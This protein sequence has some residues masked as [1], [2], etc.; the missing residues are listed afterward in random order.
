MFFEMFSQYKHV[1]VANKKRTLLTCNPEQVYDA[2]LEFSKNNDLF[3]NC[4]T[5][6]HQILEISRNILDMVS[7]R[8]QI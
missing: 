3:Q 2:I 4:Q 8:L 1:L 7:V 6:S 5:Y